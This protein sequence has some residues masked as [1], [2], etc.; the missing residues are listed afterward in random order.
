LAVVCVVLGIV[1]FSVKKKA[2]E[3]HDND[4]LSINNFS[5]KL[6]VA[7]EKL[8]EQQRVNGT[9]EKQVEDKKA[10]IVTLT[11]NV[12]KITDDLNKITGDLHKSEEALRASQEEVKKADAKIADLE[13]QNQQLDK[14]ALN[15]TNS[16][17][18]LSIEIADTQKRLAASEGDKADLESQLKRLMAEKKELERQFNDI[19]VLRAQVAKLK[20]ELNISRRIEW[21]RQGLF[22]GLEEKGAQK[23]MTGRPAPAP[24]S[25]TPKPG[26]DLN[27]EIRSDGSV[28]VIPP[29]TNAPAVAPK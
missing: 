12:T 23:L 27:V 24:A 22:A 21:I 11:N 18:K 16:I 4:V 3:E 13:S 17:T 8:D 19:T 2:A 9:L 20:E 25:K 7:N 29:G 1:A 15:L 6:I 5:N 28:K 14:Q 26:Y 10:E